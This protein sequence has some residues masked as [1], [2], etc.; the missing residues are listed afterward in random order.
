MDFGVRTSYAD[1]HNAEVRAGITFG[2]HVP[3]GPRMP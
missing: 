1:Q 2:K 3:H